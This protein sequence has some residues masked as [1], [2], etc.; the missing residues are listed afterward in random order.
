[1]TRCA[2]CSNEASERTL[3]G[4][5]SKR[6][7]VS[8]AVCAEQ[9]L[10]HVGEPVGAALIDQWGRVHKIGHT[11]MVGRQLSGDGISLL[12]GSVSRHHAEI[13]ADADAG[14]YTLHDLG[15]TNGT[16]IGDE[17]VGDPVVLATGD[18]LYFGDVGFFFVADSDGLSGRGPQNIAGKTV[19][20]SK[21]FAITAGDEI[22][23]VGLIELEMRVVEPTGGGGGFVETLGK[24]VQLTTT[25]FEF[26]KLL[27]DRMCDEEHQPEAVRGYVRSSE[28]I[29]RLSWDTAHPTDNHVKQLVRGTRK[30]LMRAGVGNLI[31]SQHRF[32]YRLRVVPIEPRG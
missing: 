22:T 10:S 30:A 16:L 12:E 21:S 17:Q 32:G 5:C 20:P 24:H 31:H 25:Q 26:V 29:A 2:V 23:K 15:S 18:S 3:C 11:T 4:A 28:L 7:T 14:K 27:V 19:K 8:N 1:M 6:L 9:V 13:I